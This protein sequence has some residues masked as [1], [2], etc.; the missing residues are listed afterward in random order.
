MLEDLHDFWEV[1]WL[2]ESSITIRDWRSAYFKDELKARKF[3]AQQV[4]TY[5]SAHITIRNFTD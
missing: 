3:L 2:R 4:N 1:N 5:G